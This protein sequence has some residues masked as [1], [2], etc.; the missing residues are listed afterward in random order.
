MNLADAEVLALST[1]KQ[2]MEEKVR[3]IAHSPKCTNTPADASS[4]RLS[5]VNAIGPC[6]QAQPRP[7]IW[8]PPRPAFQ[9]TATTVDI[10]KVAPSY[11]LYSQ[12]EVEGVITR[13]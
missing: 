11:H 1:L 5:A 3:A 2:V 8:P 10:A 12:E 7:H 6:P 9:V 13:L 4:Q